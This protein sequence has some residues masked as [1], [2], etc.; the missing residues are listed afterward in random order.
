MWKAR[1][2]IVSETT[3]LDS[4]CY[5]TNFLKEVIARIDLVSPVVSLGE[6]IPKSLS[7]VAL[8]HFPIA[9]PH[10][11][12]VQK[13]RLTKT[14]ATA[15]PES[16]TEWNFHGSNREKRLTIVKNALFIVYSQYHK[17]ETLRV[18]IGEILQA[19]LAAF[20]EAQASRLGLR[21]INRIDVNGAGPLEW[22]PYIAPELLGIF[23]FHIP[24]A[25]P[26][27]MFHNLEFKF[28]DFNLRFQFGVHNP[29]YPA[30]I[31]RRD[32]ILDY[33]AYAK[34]PLEQGEILGTL[35][36]YHRSIQGLFERSITED[37]RGRM[38]DG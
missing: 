10:P 4:I 34:G 6:Q 28:G 2:E 37:L 16:F 5:T 15:E 26:V 35:D 17:Y 21:Y 20:P 1:T 27:R 24:D 19:F 9:E 29:D 3:L 22:S 36:G 11:V 23:H 32:F 38:R 14:T 33:D 7:A 8:R 13:L 30:P 18:E 12:E 31:R 25:Q